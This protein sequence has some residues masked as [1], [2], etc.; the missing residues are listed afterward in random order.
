MGIAADIILLVVTAF[1]CGAIAQRLGQ[2]LI[3]GYIVAGVLVGPHTGG[4]AVSNAHDIEVLAEIGV[5]LLLFALGIEFSFQKLRPVRKVALIGAPLQIVLTMVLGWGLGGWLGWDWRASLWLG[6]MISQSSSMIALKTLMNQGWLG[7]LS[8]KVMIGMSVVQDLGTVPFLIILPQLE[9]P[10]A[11]LP[12]LGFAAVKTAL[13]LTSMV[14]LGTRLLPPLLTWI[15]RWRSRE[16]FLLAVTA[17]GLGVGYGTYLL[18]LSFAFGAFVAGMV[19]S[20]SDFGHQALSDVVPVRDLFGLLFF[21]SVGML[22]EPSYLLE[23]L[24]TVLT[25]VGIVVVGKATIFAG[26]SRLFGYGN[27]VPLAV[28]LTLFNV[29]EFSFVLA[30]AGLSSGSITREAYTLVLTTAII[31]M[32]L[33]PLVSGQT[34]R[35]YGMWRKRFKHEPLETINVP[36]GGLRDHVVV[37]GGGRVGWQIGQVLRA[38][39]REFVIVELDQRRVEQA[40]TAGISVVFGDASQEIV[41]EAAGIS[42]ARLLLVTT[43]GL[44]EAR[45]VVINAKR[46]NPE[47]H[48]V[49]RASSP[50]HL[51]EF[52]GLKVFEVVQ[53]EYEAA[54][55]M[56]RQA[57]LHLGLGA[58]DIQRYTDQV[59]QQMYAP[60]AEPG[61]SQRLLSQ[62]RAAEREFDLHW[63]TIGGASPLAGSTI[64]E[65]AIRPVTGASVVGVLRGSELV[66][67]PHAGFRLEAGDLVAVIGSLAA[68]EGFERLAA[69]RADA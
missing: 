13:F 38:L 67:N 69:P 3:L 41:L 65:A 47:L 53:P 2:P 19:L 45:A 57:L 34:A 58:A 63:V 35:I 27:V 7:T 5:A 68:W 50:E 12:S 61:P 60:L 8:S 36:A 64:G 22:F 56:T 52:T 15:A 46:L 51:A 21:A 31:T 33:T 11:G 37:A 40:K 54:L 17:I 23:H 9:N 20:E 30:R 59:R 32:A 10:A 14:L 43:P 4:F 25:V 29:G 1:A 18:G 48:V 26:V 6:A 49:A 66:A 62:L 28:G 44:V 24:P 16:L 55:E 39:G 42:D